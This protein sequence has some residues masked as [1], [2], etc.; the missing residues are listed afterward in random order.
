MFRRSETKPRIFSASMSIYPSRR[1]WTMRVIA[2]AVSF[3]RC[4]TRGRFHSM[5]LAF[6][7]RSWTGSRSFSVTLVTWVGFT[8]VSAILAQKGLIVMAGRV[9]GQRVLETKPCVVLK[10]QRIS[11]KGS[12]LVNTFSVFNLLLR[13]QRHSN[14]YIHTIAVDVRIVAE[15]GSVF[16]PLNSQMAKATLKGALHPRSAKDRRRLS[17]CYSR[18]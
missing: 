4:T 17:A 5:G 13:F 12:L 11:L 8:P 6:C 7:L 2:I 14:F 18:P 15:S 3:S 9:C 1:A 10:Q 16:G